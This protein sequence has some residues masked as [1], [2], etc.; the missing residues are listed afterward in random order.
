MTSKYMAN[1]KHLHFI[2]FA[3]RQI[4]FFDKQD[5]PIKQQKTTVTYTSALLLQVHEQA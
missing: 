1:S 2:F 5:H 4:L 3:M